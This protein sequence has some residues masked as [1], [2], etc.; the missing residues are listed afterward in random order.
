GGIMIV[1]HNFDSEAGFTRSYLRSGENM[2]GPTWRNLL[3]FLQSVHIA[4]EQCFF[5]NV[6]V[7]LVAGNSAVGAFPGASDQ[8][9]VQ[10]CQHFLL[11]QFQ[12]MQPRL[13]LSLGAHVPRFLAQLSPELHKAWSQVRQLRTADE[14]G[15][16]VVHPV[17]I[18][19]VEKPIA[20][21][22]LTH[23]A[24]RQLNARYRC[25]GNLEGELAE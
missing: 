3:E 22:A 2:K 11:K 25:Y 6:Y 16:G 10:W 12:L 1:G 14:Q 19:G 5:T 9:F 23:P 17:T 13:A 24:Y 20:A 21:V 18:T 7:G 8:T 4:P 15:S